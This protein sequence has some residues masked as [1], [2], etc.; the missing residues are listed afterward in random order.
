MIEVKQLYAGYDG[1]TVLDNVSVTI[2][3]EKVTVILGTNG[4]GK[5]TLLKC[6]CQI[7]KPFS[8]EIMIDGD[9]VSAL[10]H[11]ERAKRVSYLAQSRSV[12]EIVVRNLVLHGRFPYL[13]Y[14]RRYRPEDR[15]A[16][17]EALE[18]LNLSAFADK[19]VSELSGGER[20]KVY[21]AMSLAQGSHT[22]LFDEPT[23]YL[24]IAHQFSILDEA[25]ELC[26][27]GK[28]V[29][30]VLHDIPQALDT[31]DHVIVLNEGHVM[32]EDTPENVFYSGVLDD[33]FGVRVERGD[34]HYWC[35]RPIS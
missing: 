28:S 17:D 34:G 11:A 25:H 27:E 3:D 14:P 32:V 8:G 16:V 6:I 35:R 2:P 20:Q 29:V 26:L 22:L 1:R 31:A 7:V 15:M 4:S 18:R 12:P 24:D 13:S 33:V 23:T 9:D 10:T 30:M 21:L 5:S 19:S